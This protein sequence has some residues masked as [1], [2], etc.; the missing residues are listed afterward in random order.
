[1]T[2]QIDRVGVFRGNIVESGV[3]ETRNGFPQYTVR[4][5]ATQKYVENSDEMAA[6][7]LTEPGW[8][9]WASFDQELLGFLVLYMTDKN[10]QGVKP[11][12]QLENVQ[13]ATGWDGASFSGLAN[14]A[15]ADA[16][17]TFWVEENTYE[18]NT[19]LRISTIDAGD[20]APVRGLKS[21]DAEGL[22]NLDA[23]FANML[24]PKTVV[25]KP[26]AAPA[27]APA[28]AAKP[29]AVAAPKPAAAPASVPG[30]AKSTTAPASTANAAQTTSPSK[31][32]PAKAATAAAVPA[33]TAA[34]T[35]EAAWDKLLASR[36]AKSED[37]AAGAWLTASDSICPGKDETTITEPEWAK[38]AT[39]ATRL[40]TA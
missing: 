2:T 30:A 26:V 7:S 38:I 40:L 25:A 35:R 28:A 1:M 22:K 21:L 15:K 34:M 20:A 27:K 23:K 37:D 31:G 39:E 9:E 3:G 16:L 19:T 11:S 14:A 24:Q 18:G 10:T 8:V 29:A 36:G 17:V 13:R 5:K 6:F 12:F 33:P 32:P 4:I